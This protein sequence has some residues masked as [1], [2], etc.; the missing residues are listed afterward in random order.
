MSGNFDD[1][2]NGKIPYF[3]SFIYRIDPPEESAATSTRHTQLIIT[4]EERLLL[5]VLA[6]LLM[7]AA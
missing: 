4:G 2:G 5:G 1:G 3:S 7:L 6:L